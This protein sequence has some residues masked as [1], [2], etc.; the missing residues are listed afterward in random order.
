[1]TRG[2]SLAMF[3]ALGL[4]GC[5]VIVSSRRI[6]VKHWLSIVSTSMN[7]PFDSRAHPLDSIRCPR[8]CD[9]DFVQYL[10]W[11]GDG[12]CR[13]AESRQYWMHT[14]WDL[15]LRC[16]ECGNQYGVKGVA[17]TVKARL[18]ALHESSNHAIQDLVDQVD[19]EIVDAF[20]KEHRPE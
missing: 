14:V 10:V 19:L 3:T 4:A 5:F 16:G 15:G 13:V 11:D 12:A 1:M 9:P 20:L 6:S 2:Q 8:G 7:M 17:E 18:D